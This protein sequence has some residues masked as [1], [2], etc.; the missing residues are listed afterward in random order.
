MTLKSKK[1][2]VVN[3]YD[4]GGNLNSV[5]P[6]AQPAVPAGEEPGVLNSISNTIS[7]AADSVSSFFTSKNSKEPAQTVIKSRPKGRQATVNNNPAN[8]GSGPARYGRTRPNNIEAQD[9]LNTAVDQKMKGATMILI[10]LK[11]F[12]NS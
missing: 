1:K 3:A 4:K 11:M 9:E 2:K 12:K 8:I 7:D 10:I 6:S 5:N